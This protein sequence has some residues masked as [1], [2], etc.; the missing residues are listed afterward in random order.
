MAGILVNW[1]GYH[2]GWLTQPQLVTSSQII[3]FLLIW[4][5]L[6]LISRQKQSVS[7][8]ALAQA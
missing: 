7:D 5:V 4:A 3:G 8:G 6:F 2:M 1:L